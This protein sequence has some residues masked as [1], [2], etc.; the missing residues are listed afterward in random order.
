MTATLATIRSYDDLIVALRARKDRLQ[1]TDATMD[2]LA[3]WQSGYTGKLFGPSQVKKLGGLSFEL[4]LTTLG[5]RLELVED[6]EAVA[7]MERRWEQRERPAN[8][9]THRISEALK[10]RV[11]SAIFRDMSKKAAEARKKIKPSVRR[12]IAKH[13]NKVRQMKRKLRAMKDGRRKRL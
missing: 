10:E 2:A 9:A 3:G 11:K 1:L 8:V 4:A 12:R 5:V 6:P 7:M 13:A